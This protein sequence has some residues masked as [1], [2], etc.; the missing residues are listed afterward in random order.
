MCGP[1]LHR[2]DRY[3]DPLAGGPLKT[4]NGTLL[5]WIAAHLHHDGVDCLIWPFGEKGGGYGEVRVNGLKV[6]AHRHMCELVNGPP[7]SPLHEAAHSCGHGDLGCVHPKH[8]RWA[9]PAE[10][11]ADRLLH[12]TDMRG[13][14]H[15]QQKLTEADVIAI[16]ALKGAETQRE[17]ALRFGVT[18]EMISAIQRRVS[19]SWLP[20]SEAA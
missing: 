5:Q 20:E 6:L 17:T 2:F 15:W 18:R 1:H 9:T 8:L 12:G 13:E 19:W 3:G 7:P 10:N 14:K 4:P 16:R 11:Q